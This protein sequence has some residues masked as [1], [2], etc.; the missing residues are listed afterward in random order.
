MTSNEKKGFPFFIFFPKVDHR[1]VGWGG[2][3]GRERRVT[4]R[5]NSN[6]IKK[7]IFGRESLS[8]NSKTLY[9]AWGESCGR[10]SIRSGRS[11]LQ[12][13]SNEKLMF[14]FT[15]VRTYTSLFGS[16]TLRCYY[17]ICVGY[18]IF[19]IFMA[20]IIV[21]AKCPFTVCLCLSVE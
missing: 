20:R 10:I 18:Y 5:W 11:E 9:T 14:L 21:G 12:F 15:R 17:V 2:G 19:A 6:A 16:V 4:E 8:T 13:K 3:G 1:G 7:S